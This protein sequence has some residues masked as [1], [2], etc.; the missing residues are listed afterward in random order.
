MSAQGQQSDASFSEKFLA[1]E[2]VR[3]REL[4]KLID[5]HIENLKLDTDAVLQKW[6]S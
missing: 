3:A 1:E 2:N 4:E 6:V 5:S